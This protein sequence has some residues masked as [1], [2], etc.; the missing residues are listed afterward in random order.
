LIAKPFY[1]VGKTL[2]INGGSF[3]LGK[4]IAGD[5]AQVWSGKI[6]NGQALALTGGYAEK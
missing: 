6:V 3:G 4:F 1:V 5:L 2:L